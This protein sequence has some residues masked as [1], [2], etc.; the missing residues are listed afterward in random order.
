MR[1]SCV[2]FFGDPHGNALILWT[3]INCI[4]DLSHSPPASQTKAH[5]VQYTAEMKEQDILNQANNVR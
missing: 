2:D 3:V 4:L 5:G 1:G